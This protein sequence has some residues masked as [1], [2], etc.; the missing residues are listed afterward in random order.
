V[1]PQ[2][3]AITANGQSREVPEGATLEDVVRDLKPDP[4][5][6]AAAVNDEVVPRHE[7]PTRRLVGGD[8]VEV[9]TAAQG[10]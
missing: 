7:W 8:R 9:L 6:V 5:G 10:G 1:T 4:R 2:T 3:I